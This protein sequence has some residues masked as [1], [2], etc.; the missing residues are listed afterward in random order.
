MLSEFPMPREK[1]SPKNMSFNNQA[2]STS[3]HKKTP[4]SQTFP[5]TTI[6]SL[7]LCQLKRLSQPNVKKS[8]FTY[9]V[10]HAMCHLQ[11]K[12]QMSAKN[13]LT[14]FCS[15]FDDLNKLK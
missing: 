8:Q 11:A 2:Q 4:D 10:F 6:A 9:Y 14:F 12:V 13:K 15:L 3:I 5:K 7:L 1:K